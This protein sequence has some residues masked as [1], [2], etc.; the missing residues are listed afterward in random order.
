MY[1]DGEKY[2]WWEMYNPI[3]GEFVM[4]YFYYMGEVGK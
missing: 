1:T 4:R 3:N 2:G